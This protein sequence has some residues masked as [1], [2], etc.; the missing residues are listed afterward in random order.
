MS[1]FVLD[2]SA[3]LAYIENE[4]GSNEVE[5]L[6]TRSLD[7]EATLFVSSVSYIEVF[8]VS[9]RE[10][11]EEVAIER[12]ELLND[13]PLQQEPLAESLIEIVGEIKVKG[14]MS[15]ADC[16][17]AGLAKLKQATL[18]H[19]DPE[20]EQIANEIIQLQLPYKSKSK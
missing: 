7:G 15:F 17:I 9:W 2:T 20:Y 3:L 18:V 16:C 10:Q 13:L 6:F 1:R 14:A 12:L 11:G 19:K 5:G 8:Y 4:P